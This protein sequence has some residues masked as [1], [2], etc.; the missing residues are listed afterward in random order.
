MEFGFDAEFG[1]FGFDGF[2]DVACGVG[3][4][5]GDDGLGDLSFC[6]ERSSKEAA[7]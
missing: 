7:G 5:A 3:F 2:F 6:S 4:Y 1:G